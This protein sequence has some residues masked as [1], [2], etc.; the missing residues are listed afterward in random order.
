M[1]WAGWSRWRSGVTSR[2]ST[3]SDAPRASCCDRRST[4]DAPNDNVAISIGGMGEAWS[5]E[6]PGKIDRL[7]AELG[8]AEGRSYVLSYSDDPNAYDRSDTFGDLRSAARRLDLLLRRVACCI[9][10]SG[11]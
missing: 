10:R 3:R 1:A 7:A 6:A 5:H 11:R 4:K 8:Y 9:S 2:A